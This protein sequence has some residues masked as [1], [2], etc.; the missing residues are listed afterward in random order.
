MGVKTKTTPIV[1]DIPKWY[2]DAWFKQW[3]LYARRD[4]HGRQENQSHHY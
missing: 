1:V 3:E 2:D 4:Y